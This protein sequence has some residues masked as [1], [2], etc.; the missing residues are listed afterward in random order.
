[1][2]IAAIIATIVAAIIGVLLAPWWTRKYS[3]K[4]QP[5][6]AT[7]SD[8]PGIE[9]RDFSKLTVSAQDLA[10]QD[11]VHQFFI[12]KYGRA[13]SREELYDILDNMIVER[14]TII[15]IK[16]E[17]DRVMEDIWQKDARGE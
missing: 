1:M 11:A 9:N 10:I 16:E 15:P 14:G 17:V 4:H 6:T 12:K 13:P 8:A 7:P 2:E 5:S 3:E